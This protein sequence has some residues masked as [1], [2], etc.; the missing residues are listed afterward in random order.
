[1]CDRRVAVFL[2]CYVM[3]SGGGGGGFSISTQNS[4]L[5]QNLARIYYCRLDGCMANDESDDKNLVWR[6][7]YFENIYKFFYFEFSYFIKGAILIMIR[8]PYFLFS[9]HHC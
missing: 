4:T 2:A 7:R 9:V 1:M 6:K 5:D 8:L 3:F